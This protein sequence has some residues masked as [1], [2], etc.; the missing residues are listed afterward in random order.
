MPGAKPKLPVLS[1]TFLLDPDEHAWLARLAGRMG[2]DKQEALRRV[3]QDA[4]HDSMRKEE[5]RERLR[6]RR[7]AR[8]RTQ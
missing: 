7:R 6:Q 2:L 8:R 5:M 4:V 3:L 1:V